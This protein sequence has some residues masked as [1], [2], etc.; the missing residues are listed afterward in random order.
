MSGKKEYNAS[1][2]GTLACWPCFPENPAECISP[3]SLQTTLSGRTP[4]RVIAAPGGGRA[5]YP[6]K[7]GFLNVHSATML[8]R[9]QFTFEAWVNFREM[10]AGKQVLAELAGEHGKSWSF[11]FNRHLDIEFAWSDGES[12]QGRVFSVQMADLLEPGRWLHAAVAFRN[13]SYTRQPYIRDYSRVHLYLTPHGERFPRIVG[14]LRNFEHP[15]I[16]GKPSSLFIGG[17]AKLKYPFTGAVYGASFNSRAKL[18]NEFPELGQE[19]P[20]EIEL[21]SDFTAGSSFFPVSRGKYD[22]VVGCKPYTGSGNYWFYARVDGDEKYAGK[23]MKF[24][25]LPVPGGAGMLMSMFVSYGNDDWERI[26]GGHYQSDRESTPEP[27]SYKFKCVFDRFPAWLCTYIPYTLDHIDRLEKDTAGS[28]MVRLLF[29]ASSVEGR[30]IRLFKI[31]DPSVPDS[32]KKTFYLQA[33]QHSP[34]EMAPG[35]VIDRAARFLAG[36]GMPG[37][38]KKAVFLMVP[39]VNVDCCFH[40]GAG[41]NMNRINTNR[42][43]MSETQPEVAGL[44]SFIEKWLAEGNDI[45]LALDF[46]SGGGWKNHVM[47]LH[48]PVSEEVSCLQG[49]FMDFLE[50]RTGVSSDDAIRRKE[51]PGTFA[52]YLSNVRGV[53]ARTL[54]FS[55]MTYRE[56]AGGTRAV[57]QKHLESMGPAVIRALS[58]FGGFGT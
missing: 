47:L 24:E 6:E 32:E 15:Q 13:D 9:Q 8:I 38:L 33:G 4:G 35:R 11:G 41:A 52:D 48:E 42:D 50:A 2:E 26:R 29:P 12:R 1:D 30:P 17:D 43:W 55:H 7:K 18:A 44:K 16:S 5:F 27:G 51:H 56:P 40:G 39:I 28:G 45:S 14:R 54:E 10:P 25:V 31:T 58:D 3:Y 19:R 20:S 49:R 53:Y 46:H 36:G 22:M 57:D 37:L 34:A 23:E 21:S